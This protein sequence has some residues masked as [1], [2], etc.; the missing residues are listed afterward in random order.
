[1]IA[2]PAF[3]WEFCVVRQAIPALFIWR[4]Q[5]SLPY[6]TCAPLALNLGGC[7]I[8]SP[9]QNETDLFLGFQGRLEKVHLKYVKHIF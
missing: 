1:M 2:Q 5:S 3:G 7:H 6:V 4:D 9:T 8:V